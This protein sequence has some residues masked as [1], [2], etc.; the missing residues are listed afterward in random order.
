MNIWIEKSI[1]LANQKDYL[2]QLFKVYPMANNLKRELEESTIK[3]IKESFEKNNNGELIKLFL[4]QELFPIKDSYVAY[5]RKDKTAIERNPNTINRLAGM[6]YEMGLE[7][8]IFN[9][10]LPKET[11]R[12]IG[13]LFSNWIKKGSLG[14]KITSDTNEFLKIEG[15]CIFEGSDNMMEKLAKEHL[16]YQHNKGLDFIAKIDKKYIIGEAKFLTDFGGHQNT[17]LADALNV[18]RS[19]FVDVGKEIIKI[20]ILDGVLYIPNKGKM[21]QQ[22]LDTKEDEIIISA[23]FL[24][25]F[26]YSL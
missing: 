14:I 4:E 5:L 19:E 7:E 10:T 26:L 8:T 3:K 12:Q 11:N 18:I 15:N 21:H 6:V 9:M 22:L 20:A 25:D 17:Q 13:P 2:D 16:G 1:E 24:R 23:L